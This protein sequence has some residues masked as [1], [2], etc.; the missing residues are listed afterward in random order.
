VYLAW[1]C[2]YLSSGSSIS[3]PVVFV[4]IVAV[5]L[6]APLQL[7]FGHSPQQNRLYPD[8]YK[9]ASLWRWYTHDPYAA[10]FGIYLVY[11]FG[12]DR[13]GSVP[14]PPLEDLQHYQFGQGE[15]EALTL[16]ARLGAGTVMIT[17]DSMAQGW[18]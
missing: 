17:G 13:G 8:P 9:N 14:S 7:Q 5:R 6:L 3:M 4:Q 1:E 16:T 10:G 18:V 2:S 12:E 11:W 15:S